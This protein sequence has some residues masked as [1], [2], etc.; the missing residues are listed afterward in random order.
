M[1]LQSNSIRIQRKN[2]V[3]VLHTNSLV[4]TSAVPGLLLGEAASVDANPKHQQT[5]HGSNSVGHNSEHG[6]E[7]H[8]PVPA[9]EIQHRTTLA[10]LAGLVRADCHRV[11]AYPG[12]QEISAG[13]G[14]VAFEALVLDPGRQVTGCHGRVRTRAG[15]ESRSVV[16]IVLVYHPGDAEGEKSGCDHEQK[17]QVIH[18]LMWLLRNS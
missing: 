6:A 18:F 11:L 8:V 5:G 3:P 15:T 16:R 1:I 13:A 7:G 9:I 12:H 17:R 10:Q 14:S 2:P 4:P